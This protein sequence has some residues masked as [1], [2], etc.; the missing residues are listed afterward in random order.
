M[1]PYGDP[2]V[3][4]SGITKLKVTFQDG[5]GSSIGYLG[6]ATQKEVGTGSVRRLLKPTSCVQ[7]A[8]RCR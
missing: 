6:I 4:L 5:A 3:G 7:I 2:A 1:V 8:C